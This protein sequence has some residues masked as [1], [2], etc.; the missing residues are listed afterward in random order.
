MTREERPTCPGCGS[1]Q[2]NAYHV[3]DHCLEHHPAMKP[4]RNKINKMF[5]EER[6][7]RIRGLKRDMRP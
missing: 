5:N 6:I 4:V 1:T 2:L 3:C 7:R